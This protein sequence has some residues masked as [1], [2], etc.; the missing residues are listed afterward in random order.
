M[1]HKPDGLHSK[2]RTRLFTSKTKSSFMSEINCPC[3]QRRHLY[4]CQN[5]SSKFFFF[6][7]CSI[8]SLILSV[9]NGIGGIDEKMEYRCNL[10]LRNPHQ[11]M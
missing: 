2:D 1:F 5:I 6:K 9:D 4:T 11:I 8:A 7:K 3:F 10:R